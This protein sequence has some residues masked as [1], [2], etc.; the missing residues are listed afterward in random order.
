MDRQDQ[1]V[2]ASQQDPDK[3]QRFILFTENAGSSNNYGAELDATWYATD[4]LQIYSS[5]GWLETAYG[6]YQY[7]DKYGTEVDLSGRDLAHSPHFTYS[8]G[9]T[10]RTN[11]GWFTNLNLSGKSEFYYSD[12]NESRSEPY[13]IVNAR[14]GY[15]ASAWSAYL[16][17]RNLF[18][19]EYGVRGFYFGNE[20]DNGWAE[21]QYIR[22]G[23]P[24]QIGVTFNVKFM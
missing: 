2:A 8:L 20:P 9:G 17:G 5:F 14:V 12:S 15:E 1:Q 4:N 13:T 21:K 7:Q 16:W 10:Y 6:D 3:P 24:R 11:S 18:N 19:E 23:D 22:Y